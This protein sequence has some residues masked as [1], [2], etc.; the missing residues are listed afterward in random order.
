[1]QPPY[2][3]YENPLTKVETEAISQPNPQQQQTY[4]LPAQRNLHVR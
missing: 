2:N 3:S 4:W 1:M